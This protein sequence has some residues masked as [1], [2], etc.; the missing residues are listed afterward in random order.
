M[1]L[2]TKLSLLV[3]TA[4][5]CTLLPLLALTWYHAGEIA[6]D[7][8]K[9]SFSNLLVVEKES[10]NASYLHLLTNKVSDVLGARNRLRENAEQAYQLIEAMTKWEGKSTLTRHKQLESL[11][12]HTLSNDT[13]T[14]ACVDGVSAEKENKTF[15]LPGVEEDI[16]I[17]QDM[18][19]AK[20]RTLSSLLRNLQRN[21]DFAVFRPYSSKFGTHSAVL[22]FFLPIKKYLE[23]SDS[24]LSD[25]ILVATTTLSGLE[26]NAQLAERNIIRAAQEKFATLSLY[27]HGFIV[28]MDE[29]NRILA[30][31]GSLARVSEKKDI[32]LLAPYFE[33]AKKDGYVEANIGYDGSSDMFYLAAYVPAFHWMIVMAAPM[34]EISASSEILLKRLLVV[35]IGGLVVSM[36]VVVLFL[37]IAM[38]PLGLLSRKA[39]GLPDIDFSTKEAMSF[40]AQ[41]L[42]IAHQDEIGQLAKAFAQMGERLSENVSVLLET[43]ASKERM[44]GELNTAKDIQLGI[45][46]QPGSAPHMPDFTASAFMCPAKEV[47]GDLYDFFTLPDGRYAFILGDVSGK[48]VPA[49][50]FMAIT[51]SLVRYAMIG[52]LNPAA[53]MTHISALIE[54][55][56]PNNMFVTLFLSLYD[57]KT[58]KL[59]Y[60]NGGHCLPY[61]VNQ[62]GSVR[63]LENLSGPLVGV[64][65]GVEY[66]PFQDTLAEGELCLLFSDGVTEDLDENDEL[67]G[68]DRLKEFLTKHGLGNP[69]TL[70]HELFAD[71]TRFHG[72]RPQPDDITMLAFA[73]RN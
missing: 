22:A 53:A 52:G 38:R 41:G 66:V 23:N 55:H 24:V 44:Q 5:C 9:K 20:G 27:K 35:S 72:T 62:D 56:N 31:A 64:M 30:S 4:L 28:L 19:D 65:P 12:L 63:T 34:A 58:G 61:I 1:T 16:A 43:T 18:K 33:K 49:A 8:E 51:V 29:K 48:G 45:L 69:E 60:A 14:I 6:L 11:L 36:I 39:Q 32:A 10:L 3:A 70:L 7:R 15:L 57:P 68:E 50:L 26:A 47:G 67:Y 25:R 2:R 71:L 54:E 59:E 73:R 46:P 42:P 37:S 40:F 21:G 17:N 13:L